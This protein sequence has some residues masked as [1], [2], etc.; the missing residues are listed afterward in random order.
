MEIR[1]EPLDQSVLEIHSGNAGWIWQSAITP[2]DDCSKSSDQAMD[3][4]RQIC[5]STSTY[6][7]EIRKANFSERVRC[8]LQVQVKS[9]KVGGVPTL[10]LLM[11]EFY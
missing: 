4:H 2:Q 3:I 11:R 1:Q 9:A 6:D 7:M 8:N 10:V 5:M